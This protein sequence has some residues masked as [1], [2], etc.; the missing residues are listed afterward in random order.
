MTAPVPPGRVQ[1]PPLTAGEAEIVARFDAAPD[2]D[3]AAEARQE[4]VARALHGADTG[5]HGGIAWDDPDFTE[6]ERDVYRHLAAAAIAAVDA[7]R[8]GQAGGLREQIAETLAFADG[9]RCF[10]DVVDAE[11]WD[12]DE[13][14]REF[15]LRR[16]DALL[17]GPLA[18]VAPADHEPAAA[19]RRV[20]ELA[21][22]A[23]SHG[24]DLDPDDVLEALAAVSG[25]QPAAMEP[26][27]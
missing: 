3:L 22:R 26:G 6:W 12:A 18:A 19:I 4:A 23:N 7:W 20:R 9:S 21:E 8:G 10:D 13:E 14:D 2:L 17:A 11:M 24:Y 27:Q 25:V 16:A 5:T 15:Y 1:A